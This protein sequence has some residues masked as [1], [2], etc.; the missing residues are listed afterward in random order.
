MGADSG[1][2]AFEEASQGNSSE[3]EAV[4]KRLPTVELYAAVE[5]EIPFS[6][7]VGALQCG[8]EFWLSLRVLLSITATVES[9][10]V[11]LLSLGSAVF[12]SYFQDIN[13]ETLA[14]KLDFSLLSISLVFPVTFLIQGGFQRRER[15]IVAMAS[16]KAS[17]LQLY[18]GFLSWNTH[19]AQNP[20]G[21]D[22][23]VFQTLASCLR[24]MEAAIAL[25][26]TTRRRHFFTTKGRKFREEIM[27]R[28]SLLNNEIRRKLY[29]LHL[30][31]NE[32]KS[33]GLP[34]GEASRLEQYLLFFQQHFEQ[35]QAIK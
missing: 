24:S 3:A 14:A 15:S 16:L 21:F 6:D 8:I 33:R 22:E 25:P 31:V 9:L 27:K 1:K 26:T 23:R 18:M 11:L 29:D 5:K 7:R 19:R 4:L 13:G 28:T 20:D 32:L 30:C 2:E 12:F 10:I 34:G 35:L 17:A